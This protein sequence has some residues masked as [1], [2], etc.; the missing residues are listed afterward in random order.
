MNE[1]I[2]TVT[3]SASAFLD[4]IQEWPMS[5]VVGLACIIV[6]TTCRA[7]HVFPN[8]YVSPSTLCM[9]GFLNILV[10]DPGKVASNQRHPEIILFLWGMLIAFFALVGHKI[11]V[12]RY[13]K[14][15]P[16][17][18]G[19]NGGETSFLEKE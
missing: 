9:G 16:W 3:D 18:K 5:L 1:T 13:G 17:L 14:K 2:K 7:L 15:F 4:Q 11:I 8:K 10:G 12:N 19:L 6:A